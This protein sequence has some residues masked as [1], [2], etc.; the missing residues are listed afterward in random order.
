MR[1]AAILLCGGISTRFGKNKLLEAL[2]GRRVYEHTLD[3]FTRSG[4]FHEIIIVASNAIPLTD[5]VPSGSTRQESSYNGLMGCK[6][7]PDYVVIHDGARPFVSEAILERNVRAVQEHK[8]VNTCIPTHDTIN[9]VEDKTITIPERSK[10]YRGQTPQSFS[11]D[12]ILEAHQKTKKTNAPDDCS[13]ILELGHPV[14][15]VLGSEEN[16]KIT[17]PVD[18]IVAHSLLTHM[19]KSCSG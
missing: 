11:Y 7:K 16:M 4:L 18:L 17:T 6:V 8:A 10:C 2:G 12:L 3:V 5:T 1:F 9:Y 15:L 14:H 13:L 19:Q